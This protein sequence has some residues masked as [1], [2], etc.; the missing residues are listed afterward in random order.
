[1]S[2]LLIVIIVLLL[3]GGGGWGWRSGYVGPGFV[4]GGFGLVIAV[5]LI[6]VL[7]GRI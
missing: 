5:I 6:L 1:M 4:S 3:L 7:M 2:L